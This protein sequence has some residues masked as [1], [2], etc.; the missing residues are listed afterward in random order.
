MSKKVAGQ[1]CHR[2]IEAK[3]WI[4]LRQLIEAVNPPDAGAP[5]PAP[6]TDAGHY[7]Q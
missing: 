3:G 1:A 2:L 6:K 5:L 7:F 4:S